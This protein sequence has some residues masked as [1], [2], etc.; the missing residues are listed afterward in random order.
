MTTTTINS[1]AFCIYLTNARWQSLLEHIL[2]D[3]NVY[4]YFINPDPRVIQVMEDKG[5]DYELVMTFNECTNDMF[6]HNIRTLLHDGY[7][8]VFISTDESADTLHI[9]NYLKD[10]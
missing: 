4:P 5:Y 9:L 7:T 1:Q 8:P 2:E 3:E 6:Q 10:L